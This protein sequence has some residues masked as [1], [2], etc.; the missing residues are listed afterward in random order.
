LHALQ[1]EEHGGGNRIVDKLFFFNSKH[2]K[3][4]KIQAFFHREVLSIQAKLSRFRS[5]FKPLHHST[6][7]VR[8]WTT[9][10]IFNYQGEHTSNASLYGF[11]VTSMPLHVIIGRRQRYLSF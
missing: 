9:R 8:F 6:V 10:G 11:Q 5:L 4:I 1:G 2:P 7:W 3:R